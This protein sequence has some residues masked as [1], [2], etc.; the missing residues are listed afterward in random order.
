MT[1]AIGEHSGPYTTGWIGDRAHIDPDDENVDVWV[2][3][4]SGESYIATFFTLKNLATLMARYRE[5]GECASGLY[6]WGSDMIVVER[7]TDDVIERT[8]ADLLKSGEFTGAFSYCEP[9]VYED[10]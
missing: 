6:V 10:G 3:F 5:S 8:I 4:E 1:Q 7:L 2:E 9:R